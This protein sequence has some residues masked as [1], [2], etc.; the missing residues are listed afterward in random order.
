MGTIN[1]NI[2]EVVNFTEHDENNE[3]GEQI[4]KSVINYIIDQSYNPSKDT[5]IEASEETV[6]SQ[7]KQLVRRIRGDASNWKKNVISKEK[8]T[9][10]Y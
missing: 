2:F 10:G 5:L 8:K 9:Y 6:N 3:T 7:S 4:I 1:T